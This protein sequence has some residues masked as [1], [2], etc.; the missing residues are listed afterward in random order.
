[1]EKGKVFISSTIYD[2]KDLRSAL[3]YWLTELGY[4]VYESEAVDFPRDAAQN[5]YETCLSTIE[6]CDWFILFIG[7]R[8]GGTLKDETTDEIISITR[9]EY[10]TAY[11]L[12]K[13]GKIKKIITFVRTEVWQE[14]ELRK[15]LA[16]SLPVSEKEIKTTPTTSLED[17][18]ATFSFIDE[19]RCIEEIKKATGTIDSLPKGNWVNLFNDFSDI[20]QTL[21]TELKL[22]GNVSDLVWQANLKKECINNLH[23]ILVKY[24]EDVFP[25]FRVITP[26]RDKCVANFKKNDKKDIVLSIEDL[27]LLCITIVAPISFNYTVLENALLSGFFLDFNAEKNCLE[28]GE[29]NNYADTLLQ[30]IKTNNDTNAYFSEGQKNLLS[31]L[32]YLK[33]VK[34]NTISV[35]YLDVANILSIHD[36]ISNIKELCLYLISKIENKNDVKQPYLYPIR[37][38]DNFTSTVPPEYEKVFGKDMTVE[39]LETYLLTD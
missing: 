15:T 11:E 23:K 19:V 4:E 2:F 36:R 16:K 18:E 35:S 9:K 8:V 20:V 5:S 38:C 3:K 17:P 39:E 25:F 29:L 33:K 14:K 32:E 24:D 22:K 27:N 34:H 10:R 1:M 7:N 31:K 12:F 21:N 30:I 6:M 26:I 37:F 13:K 28:N